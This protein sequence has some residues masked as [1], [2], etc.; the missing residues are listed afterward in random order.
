MFLLLMENRGIDA[1]PKSDAER[2]TVTVKGA[3]SEWL[4]SGRYVLDLPEIVDM[5]DFKRDKN[6]IYFCSSG[7]IPIED[8]SWAFECYQKALENGIGVKLPVWEVSN[9]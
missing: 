6:A 9:L 7:G 5:S 8:V 3:L 2:R 1:M 4:A